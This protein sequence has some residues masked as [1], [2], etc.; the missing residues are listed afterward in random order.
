[1][2]HISPNILSNYKKKIFLILS[3][4]LIILISVSAAYSLRLETIYPIWKIN[5][6]V[7]II[8][9]AIIIGVFYYFNIYQILLRF[10]D[11]YSI[12]K[13]IKSILICILI[14]IPINFYL[15][16]IIYF[17]RSI[18]FIA[19]VI[20]GLLIIFHR[21]LVNF[22]INLN[23]KNKKKN[24]ILITGI[25]KN[26]VEI[27]KSIRQN[28]SYGKVMGIIDS[29]GNYKKRELNGIKIFKKNKIKKI[30]DDL[31]INEIIVGNKSLNKKEIGDLFSYI[32]EKNIRFKNIK[33]ENNYQNRFIETSLSTKVNFYEIIDRPKIVVDR[34]ILVNKIKNK[35][36]LITGGGGSI[37]SQL[38]LEILKHN[39]KKLLIIEISEIN[40][41]NVINEIKKNNYSL[42]KV[43]P[44]LGDC[45]DSIFLKNIF[46]DQKIDEIYHAAAYKHVT[47]GENNPYSIVKNNIF[48]TKV[49][50]ELS[51]KNKIK[52]F[53]FISSDKAVNPKSLLGFTKKFGEKLI[54]H[55]YH[56]GLNNKNF[57]TDFTIVRFGNVIGSSGSVIPIFLNQ[58]ENKS[59]LTVTNKKAKR[60]FMSIAEAVQLVINAS[61]FNKKGIKIYALD[62]GKQ[63]NIYEI[64]KRIIR[65]SGN[66]IKNKNNK[67]GDIEI[68]ITGL[69]K[70]EKISEEITLGKNLIKTNHTKIMECQENIFTNNL[71]TDLLKLNKML[72]KNNISYKYLKKISNSNN[73]YNE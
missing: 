3:D 23:S 61:Y 12:L 8:F 36:I 49:L 34:T 52:H 33:N 16:K 55:H 20:I 22:L 28:P 43:K 18:S 35:I 58:I 62:M 65:L 11:N 25:N 69:K 10:F 5:S 63:I 51:L 56:K 44:F 13:I 1:M 73:K 7:F 14:L 59:P 17:P 72:E 6:Y 27:I 54:N 15:Y 50:V 29:S 32:S 30:I 60:Y 70:G 31:S 26:N 64:A 41:F 38:C 37:G 46:K 19:P 57:I 2:K 45:A 24:N 48:G 40:L 66:T 68:R 9:S 67:S 71:I 4:L 47:F 53:T 39:P 42:K 21:I